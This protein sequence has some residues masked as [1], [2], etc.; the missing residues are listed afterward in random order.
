MDE[1]AEMEEVVRTLASIDERGS[2]TEGERRAAEWLV[3]RFRLHGWEADVEEVPAHGTWWWPIGVPVAAGALAGLLSLVGRRR[4]AALV[5]AAAAVS[6]ADDLSSGR[7]WFRKAV[8]PRRAAR[9]AVARFG[10]PG[11]EHTVVFMAHHD[12]PHTGGVFKFDAK[13]QKWLAGHFPEQVDAVDTSP[14]LWWPVIAGPALVALGSLLR[15]KKLVVA[16]TVLSATS[17]AVV[18]DVGRSQVVEGAND[19]LSGVACLVWL[20]RAMSERPPV[21]LRVILVSCGAEEALQEGI[22]GFAERHF[23]ELPAGRTWFVNLETVGSPHLAMLEGEGPVRMRDYPLEF[24]NFVASTAE[25]A[26]IP[27]RRGMRARVTT[28]S[29]VVEKAGYPVVTLTSLDE[30]KQ[31]SNYHLPS[32]VPDNL[33]FGTVEQAAR[34]AEATLRDLAET[35]AARR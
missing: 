34:L 10:D 27:L 9:N 32:D 17:A 35:V 28:D 31:L 30:F 5:G 24:R 8:L 6:I 1:R 23:G 7:R 21:G 25:K 26:G 33:D 2:A 18:A 20:A 16:G 29:L 13:A 19:N 11:A 12:A 22:L 15:R 4:L 14:P 3:E